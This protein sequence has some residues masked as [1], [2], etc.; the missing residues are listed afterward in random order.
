MNINKSSLNKIIIFFLKVFIF[1]VFVWQIVD[2]SSSYNGWPLRLANYFSFWLGSMSLLATIVFMW[3]KMRRLAI[4]AGLLT[5]LI[6]Y[7][8]L[9]LFIPSEKTNELGHKNFEI[10][11]YSVMT[12]NKE[13]NA[14]MRVIK[15]NPADI[16]FLQEVSATNQAHITKKMGSIYRESRAYMSSRNSFLTISRYPLKKLPV[17]KALYGVAIQKLELDIKGKR[18]QAWNLHFV[19]PFVNLERHKSTVTKLIASSYMVKEPLLIAG[20]FNFTERSEEYKQMSVRFANAHAVSGYS[21]GFTFPARARRAGLLGPFLRIDH[22]FYNNAFKSIST[23]VIND[24]G[25]S[26]HFPIRAT[27]SFK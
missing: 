15:E 9:Y 22:I 10:M 16:I 6:L 8:Y 27:M 19:K 26:D 18:V 12:R 1:N 13:I 7:P 23:Q 2:I 17:E 11:T 3:K 5:L 25:G 21:L 24:A 4:V 20:D 14:I